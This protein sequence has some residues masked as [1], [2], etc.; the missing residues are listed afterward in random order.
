MIQMLVD[1]PALADGFLV[2]AQIVYGASPISEALL[3]R[4]MARFPACISP[5]PTA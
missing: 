2:A 5:R 3:D 1:H 4:A